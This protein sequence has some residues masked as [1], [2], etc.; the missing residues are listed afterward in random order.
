MKVI[1]LAGGKGS[2]LWPLCK[3]EY[4]KQFASI[5]P[6]ENNSSLFQTTYKRALKLTDKNNIFIV[7]NINYKHIVKEQLQAL[8][9]D[10]DDNTIICETVGKNTLPAILYGVKVACA[11][12]ADNVI[13]FPSDHKIINED[14]MIDIIKN[15]EELAL[16]NIVTFGMTPDKPS[17]EYGYIE[18]GD[19]AINGYKVLDF[20]EKPCLEKAK[21]FIKLNYLWNS[22]IFMFNSDVFMQEAKSHSAD[23]YNAIMDNENIDDCYNQITEGTSI[24]YGIMEKTACAAVVPMNVGWSDLGGFDAFF[25]AFECDENNNLC[26][27]D[28]LTIDSKNNLVISEHTKK[29]VL[30]G[31]EDVIAVER[32]G[33]LMLCRKNESHR[34]KEAV[35]Q[36]KKE[37]SDLL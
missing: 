27:E 1:I 36:L 29:V 34:I 32:N 33:V 15:T 6:D 3:E 12:K 24:D 28:V 31:I 23:I 17:T 7:T 14:E 9:N 25:S 22:G 21:E 26:R 11:D 5:F 2:R 18:P 35:E 4:P 30:I 19:K 10:F 16:N 8:V 20:K 13:V 37:K